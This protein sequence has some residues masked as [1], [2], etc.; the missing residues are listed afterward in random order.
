MA[1]LFSH[2]VA[3]SRH[4]EVELKDDDGATMLQRF[5]T[6]GKALFAVPKKE[7]D[8]KLAQYEKQKRKRRA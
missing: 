5:E 1:S 7:I 3:A 8:K 6:F 4:P 2:A